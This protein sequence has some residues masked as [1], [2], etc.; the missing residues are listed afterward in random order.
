MVK[1]FSYGTLQF[2]RVQLDTFERILTGEKDALRKYTLSNI[3]IT[4]PNVI[5]SSGTDMHPILVYT[6][7]EMDFVEGMIFE[8][9]DKELLMADTYEV[10]DYKRSELT[11]ASGE[12]AYAYL[13][14]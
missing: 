14:K 7:A 9:T 8:L 10:D 4:D 1:L 5:K 3:K 12:S 11:F 2:E 13:K 6:G